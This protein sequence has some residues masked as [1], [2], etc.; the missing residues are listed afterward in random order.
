M[1]LPSLGLNG[2]W[3]EPFPTQAPQADGR[4][5]QHDGV[6]G[7]QWLHV[8]GEKGRGREGQYRRD[9]V[10]RLKLRVYVEGHTIHG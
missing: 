10:Y 1:R 4:W 2:P 5:G 6:C 9:R 8:Q 7:H 3:R